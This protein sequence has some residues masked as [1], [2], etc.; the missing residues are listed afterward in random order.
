MD[1]RLRDRMRSS[2]SHNTVTV[3]GRSQAIPAGPFHWRTRANGRLHA[4]RHNAAFDWVEA[5]H[6]GYAPIEHRRSMVRARRRRLAG[7]RRACSRAP[8]SAAT[9]DAA[10]R[11]SAAAHWHFDPGWMVHAGQRRTAARDAPGRRR[12]VAAVSTRASLRC[13][14]G[15]DESGLG[16]YAP[17]YGT[18]VPTWTA[19]IT[20]T[21]ARCRSRWSRGLAPRTARTETPL[22]RAPGGCNADPH[23]RAIAARVVSGDHRVYVSAPS[24]RAAVARRPG[25]RHRRLPDQRPRPALSGRAVIRS[26]RWISLMAATRWRC[27]TDGSASRPSEPI[28]RPAPD[29]SLTAVLLAARLEPPRQLRLQGTR[30]HRAPR[31]PFEWPQLPSSAGRPTRHSPYLRQR[32]GRRRRSSIWCA[33]CVGASC[34]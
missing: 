22:P 33:F 6:D 1:P 10:R 8:R 12:G 11:H 27:A 18:L 4:S 34:A 26:S 13:S 29:H 25:L 20:R 14:H 15:D 3:D 21:R 23:G 2:R 19:R 24:G 17:V 5:S 16:W 30:H 32:L 7:G 28:R 9:G 31:N